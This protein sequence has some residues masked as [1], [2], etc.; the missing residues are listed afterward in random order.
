MRFECDMGPKL[1]PKSEKREMD[2]K[3]TPAKAK[4]LDLSSNSKV[5]VVLRVRPFLPL[6][7]S[8][9]SGD[10]GGRSCVSVTKGDDDDDSS[11]VTVHLNDPDTCRNESYQL[12]AFYGGDDDNVKQIFD[13]EV[14]PLISGIFHGFNATVLAY[15]A[16]GSGKTFTMQGIDE[17]PGLMPLTM[18]TVLSMCE[19]TGSKAEISYYEVYMDRCWDLLEVKANEIAIWDDKDGQVH[20]KGLSSVQVD[21]MSEFQEVYSSGVQRRKVAHTCLN[22][23]SSRSHGVLVISVTSQG[24]V[25]GKINLIDLAGNEDNRRT[26]N[27]GIRLQESAKINQSLFALSN[28]VYALNNNLPR[29]PYRESK[30]TRILQDSLGGTS[31]ALMVACLNPGEYQESLRTVS[32]A[33]RS[34]HISN[35]VSLNL[36]V[37]TP[38]VK[39]D[40]EAKLQ[41][42]LESKGKT[43]S[44]HRM[45]AIRSPLLSTNQTSIFQSSFK[46]SICHRS[47]IAGAKFAGTGQRDAFVTERNLFGEETLAASHLWEPIQDLQLDSPTKEDERN[48]SAEEDLLVLEASF[49]DNPLDLEKKYTELSP[50]REALSPIDTNAKPKS[51][52]GSSPILKPMTPK[53]PF[54]SANPENRQMEGTCQKFNAW[55]TNLKTSLINEYIHFLNTAKREE[56]MEL[57]GIGDKMADYITELRGSSP[58]KS[59]SDLEKI[60]FTSRQVHNLFKRATEGILEKPV[61]SASTTP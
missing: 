48:T 28:V 39:I 9:E 5:R 13:R 47:A 7:I 57:K 42:W 38:K 14:S 18:S 8:D 43:K 44:T 24:F 49:K 59:L 36:K 32:L 56:L 29:V 34:R 50:L 45:M 53:T 31:R 3:K 22:D 12:D 40:M 17:L 35:N 26:G 6:E 23:V 30:L 61:S 4:I 41:A 55:S 10:G 60:G 11:H 27:E 37:E 2:S 16:T 51:A 19:K 54:L 46:K 1:C 21:S 33:A 52:D 15:G 58:L 25:T 20:L